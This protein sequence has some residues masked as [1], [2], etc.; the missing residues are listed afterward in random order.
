MSIRSIR[1]E[2][3]NPETHTTYRKA[4]LIA[5]SGNF[6]LALSKG[7]LAWLTGSS[8]I[9]SDAANSI[10]DT[11]YSL[12]MG[13][14]LYLSLQ[15]ADQNHPQG[16]SR[17]EPFVSLFI[18]SAMGFAGI[19]AIWES[20]HRFIQGTMMI[21]PGLPTVVLIG[22]VLLKV[23]M[24]RMVW[25]LGKQVKSPAIVA[26][27]RDNLTDVLTSASALVGV[28]GSVLI[29]PYFDPVLGVVIGLWI[30]RAAWKTAT[31]NLGYLAGRG[32]SQELILEINKISYKV[33]GVKNVHRII[34]DYVGP[35]VR[36]DMHI[37][38]DGNIPIKNAHTIVEQLREK[39]ENLP[40][41]DS[42]YIHVEPYRTS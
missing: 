34:A 22:A 4:V 40:D 25:R 7:F 26:S 14:G 20:F 28:W 3:S 37:E 2:K 11:F 29:H 36:V 19:T 12:L 42:V 35:K 18:A 16:H 24:F 31:E 1:S 13:F 38:V 30:M 21:R 17:F 39:I 10:S 27:A 9:F 6:V 15:P 33:P 32:A 41:V 8:A 5:F 23:G